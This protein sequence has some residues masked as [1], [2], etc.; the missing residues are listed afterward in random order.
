MI[1]AKTKFTM[2]AKGLEK[3][4]RWGM[5]SPLQKAAS[6]IARSAKAS[7]KKNTKK[8][9]P[10]GSPPYTRGQG[11]SLKKA[12][13][14]DVDKSAGQA[15]IGPSGY[16]TGMTGHFHEFGGV[17]VLKGKR[18][19]YQLGGTGPVARRSGYTTP[20]AKKTR[21]GT[22]PQATGVVFARLKTPKMV[23]RA[24]YLDQ[25]IW[26]SADNLRR[27]IYKRRTFMWPAVE[28]NRFN[29]IKLFSNSVQ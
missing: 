16:A 14:Y 3:R 28:K 25:L 20:N 17:Q 1:K 5:H 23:F 15:I 2:D 6:L 22:I 21:A 24:R 4:A 27:R 7:I 18:K 12:I 11:R 29:L 19:H 13:M 9:A 8:H 10:A 26:P